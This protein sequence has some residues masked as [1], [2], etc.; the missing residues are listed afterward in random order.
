MVIAWNLLMTFGRMPSFTML[1]LLI[2]E[3]GRTLYFLRSPLISFLRNFQ[4]LSYR[5]FTCLV[6]VTPR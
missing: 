5:Y 4:F 1:I 3:H 2:H 6:I